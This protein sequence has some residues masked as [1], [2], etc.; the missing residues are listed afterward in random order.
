MT[1]T[2]RRLLICLAMTSLLVACD[3]SRE[4]GATQPDESEGASGAVDDGEVGDSCSTDEECS[5]YYRCLDGACAVP[6]AVSG[7]ADE[8]TPQV[9]IRNPSS[10]EKVATF[11][12]EIADTEHERSKGLMFRREL[13]EGWGMLFVYDSAAP[14]SFW[15]ENTFIPL[16]MVFIDADGR[17][18]SIVEKAEP[19]TRTP[20]RS[21]GAARYV[22]ELNA[23]AVA[24]HGIE[25]GATVE[26]GGV[27]ESHLPGGPGDSAEK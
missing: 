5:S 9:T 25:P 24:E 27:P 2:T 14:R 10:G 15:M 21:D 16:D 6:P 26:I 20:R 8:E 4:R 23:G 17:I 12:V 19:L 18:D 11:H 22:L 3:K 7:E 13:A 1:P